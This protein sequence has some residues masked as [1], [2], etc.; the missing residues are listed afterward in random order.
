MTET[1]ILESYRSARPD[2][3]PSELVIL[4]GL[5][6][7]QN[8]P[9][10]LWTDTDS[11]YGAA[12]GYGPIRTAPDARTGSYGP[13]GLPVPAV[14]DPSTRRRARVLPEEWASSRIVGE[15]HSSVID[16]PLTSVSDGDLVTVAA[17]YDNESGYATRLAETAAALAHD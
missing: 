5:G 14:S 2:P 3:E 16:L 11:G 1:P 7:T 8:D 10:I 6:A 9:T 17:W 4:P 12:R 15:T 13:E